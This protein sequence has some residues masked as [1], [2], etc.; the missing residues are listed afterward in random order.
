MSTTDHEVISNIKQKIEKAIRDGYTWF[1]KRGRTRYSPLT[2]YEDYLLWMRKHELKT[3]EL[4]LK[5][6]QLTRLKIGELSPGV[7][8]INKSFRTP[9]KILSVNSQLVGT[10]EPIPISKEARPKMILKGH[11]KPNDISIVCFQPNQYQIDIIDTN[12][13]SYL[14]AIGINNRVG[15]AEPMNITNQDSVKIILKDRKSIQPVANSLINIVHQLKILQ[16]YIKFIV[17]EG[18]GEKAFETINQELFSQ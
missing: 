13:I 14:I 2:N 8:S 9:L 5:Y 10:T 6:R 11:H 7:K 15:L 16:P 3:Y 18:G 1:G 4:F 12:E 17:L